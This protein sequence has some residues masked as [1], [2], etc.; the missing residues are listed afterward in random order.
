MREIYRSGTPCFGSC[1]GLQLGAVAAGGVVVANPRGREIGFARRIQLTDSGRHHPM[2]DGKPPLF[3]A[4]AVHLDEVAVVPPATT[5]LATNAWSPVQAA[6][7]AFEGGTFWG[8]QYH[9][10]YDFAEIASVFRRYGAALFEQGLFRD[11]ADKAGYVA[12]LDALQKAPADPALVWRHGLD[13]TVTDPAIR[14]RE[15][16]NWIEKAVLPAK[17]DRGRA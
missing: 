14:H 6:E 11:E 13:A 9:P 5:V 10:E 17:S 3:D 12:D 1:W 4:I 7:I 8:V 16:K 15:L 2:F